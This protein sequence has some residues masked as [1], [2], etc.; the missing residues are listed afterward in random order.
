MSSESV[1]HEIYVPILSFAL[2]S[3]C[4]LFI[5]LVPTTV[6]SDL[7]QFSRLNYASNMAGFYSACD[8]I[9]LLK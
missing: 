7:G 4:V 8:F 1:K 5:E 3:Y 9:V 2:V 6:A